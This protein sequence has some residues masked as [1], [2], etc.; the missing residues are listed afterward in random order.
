M[1]WDPGECLGFW[2]GWLEKKKRYYS[3][4]REEKRKNNIYEK[5]MFDFWLDPNPGKGLKSRGGEVDS[6]HRSIF[7][8]TSKQQI[9]DNNK[10]FEQTKHMKIIAPVLM[11]ISQNS[12]DRN[13]AH[14]QLFLFPNVCSLLHNDPYC[15]TT[16]CGDSCFAAMHRPIAWLPP[17]RSGCLW[18]V[19]SR[20]NYKT[21]HEL[22][23]Q[24]SNTNVDTKHTR[25]LV[26]ENEE[27]ANMNR[28]SRHLP[29]NQTPRRSHFK[30][31]FRRCKQKWRWQ[32]WVELSWQV[33]AEQGCALQFERLVR[34][35]NPPKKEKSAK[36]KTLTI[37]YFFKKAMNSQRATQN[38]TKALVRPCVDHN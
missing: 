30:R 25:N 26:I 10:K 31:L 33:N 27:E 17:L 24:N 9:N 18:F 16:S 15:T 21:S 19:K 7:M 20:K 32:A 14:Q 34:N 23:H 1:G 35:Q 4:H 29:T 2:I 22:K 37:R 13:G 12:Q 3:P 8:S 36:S 6:L 28:F 11:K 38:M 5:P